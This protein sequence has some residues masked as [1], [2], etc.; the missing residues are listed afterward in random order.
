[1]AD[2]TRISVVNRGESRAAPLLICSTARP[3]LRPNSPFKEAL[4]K[5]RGKPTSWSTRPL[6]DSIPI[7]NLDLES[8]RPSLIV[9]DVVA[10]PPRA[11]LVRDAEARGC[12]VLDQLGM[13][14]NQ[15]IIGT[16]VNV[17]AFV[18]RKE[19]ENLFAS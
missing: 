12:R 5:F 17:E 11:G 2:V 3:R 9:A 7:L 1:M 15:G 10:N 13:I 6:S 4:T 14:A 18:M 19:L 8:R 16:G